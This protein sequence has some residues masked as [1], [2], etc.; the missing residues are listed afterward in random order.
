MPLVI[1]RVAISPIITQVAIIYVPLI[2]P[3]KATQNKYIQIN[4]YIEYDWAANFT[5]M[6]LKVWMNTKSF[7]FTLI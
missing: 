3:N 4:E 7:F 1:T 5:N 2:L 6:R